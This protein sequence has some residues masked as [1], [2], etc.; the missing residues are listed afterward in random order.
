VVVHPSRAWFVTNHWSGA[1]LAWEI[2][3][4]HR[5][6]A[7]HEQAVEGVLCFSPDGRRYLAPGDDLLKLSIR[8][9]SSN[10][11]LTQLSGHAQTIRCACWSPDGARVATGDGHGIVGIWDAESGERLDWLLDSSSATTSDDVT[12][13]AFTRDSKGLLVG[14]GKAATIAIWNL[15]DR[16]VAALLHGHHSPITDIQLSADGGSFYSVAR[17]EALR[18]WTLEDFPQSSVR[19]VSVPHPSRAGLRSERV[20]VPKLEGIDTSLLDRAPGIRI[21]GPLEGRAALAT[22]LAHGLGDAEAFTDAERDTDP[23][24]RAAPANPFQAL[25]ELA[26]SRESHPLAPPT[27]QTNDG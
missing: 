23:Q 19:Q 3:S 4:G 26:P 11:R 8:E 12:A 15:Q 6:G 10:R 24:V 2:A 25:R 9:W 20:N 14:T 7:L 17:E 1:C 27:G 22:V 5:V 21:F 13:L 16:R 18:V